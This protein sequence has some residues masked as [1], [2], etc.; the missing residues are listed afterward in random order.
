[1]KSLSTSYSYLIHVLLYTKNS[2]KARTAMRV[3]AISDT[4]E[5]ITATRCKHLWVWILMFVVTLVI[6]TCPTAGCRL[7]IALRNFGESVQLLHQSQSLLLIQPPH[8][9]SSTNRSTS[10]PS[11]DSLIKWILSFGYLTLVVL[12]WP[13]SSNSYIFVLFSGLTLT[14]TATV[15]TVNVS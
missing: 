14:M 10:V 2:R 9:S 1:M 15:P 13:S 6:C 3:N 12:R 5:D 7:H 8:L 11:G 4:R